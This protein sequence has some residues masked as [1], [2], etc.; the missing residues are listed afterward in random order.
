MTARFDQDCWRCD[1]QASIVAGGG[2]STS[3]GTT[4]K[5]TN[6]DNRA[7][8]DT[9]SV[10]ASGGASL[11]NV[12][13]YNDSSDPAVI[14]A[15]LQS[16]EQQGVVAAGTI[17]DLAHAAIH[18]NAALSQDAIDQ[19]EQI[20]SQALGQGGRAVSD[21]LN[22]I[23]AQSATTSGLA[24]AAFSTANPAPEI[25]K[26]IIVAAGLVAIVFFLSRSAR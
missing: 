25:I 7:A 3:S 26:A 13:V 16:V 9:G 11:S 5:T 24:S 23:A 4:E 12:A 10:A 17:N 18:E 20:A 2:G 8:A 22:A 14:T 21:A 15:A 19:W 1:V 6:Q